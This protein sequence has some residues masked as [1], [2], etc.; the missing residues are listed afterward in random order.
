MTYK[1]KWSGEVTKTSFALDLEEGVFTWDNS[2]KIA[3]SLKRSAEASTRRKAA[4]FQSAMSMLNFY[5]NRAG[6]NLKLERKKLLELTK[7][8]LR[9]L[10][11]K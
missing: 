10:F 11:N 1:K 9:K 4:P 7:V 2:K 8:E 6:K 5:I 3:A